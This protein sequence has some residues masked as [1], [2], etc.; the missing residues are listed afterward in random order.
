VATDLQSEIMAQY[1]AQVELLI[2]KAGE[3]DMDLAISSPEMV[4]DRDTHQYRLVWEHQLLDRG[5]VPLSRPGQN[6]HVY[7]DIRATMQRRGV[8]GG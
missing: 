2:R 3:A 5:A 6:W 7:R 4:Q 8:I 1:W